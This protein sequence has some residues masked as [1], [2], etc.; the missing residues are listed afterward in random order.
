MILTKALVCLVATTGY[1]N[2]L[3]EPRPIVWRG[4]ADCSAI[5][6]TVL[7]KSRC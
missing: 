5:H 1:S 4:E 6:G 2:T 3:V 7:G